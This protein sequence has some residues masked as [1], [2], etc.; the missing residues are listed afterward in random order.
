MHFGAFTLFVFYEATYNCFF[1]AINASSR[2]AWQSSLK[3]NRRYRPCRGRQ[4]NTRARY[5]APWRRCYFLFLFR[6]LPRSPAPLGFPRR[7]FIGRRAYRGGGRCRRYLRYAAPAKAWPAACRGGAGGGVY[8]PSAEVFPL[9]ACELSDF[10][11]FGVFPCR[12][13]NCV[14]DKRR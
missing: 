14:Y 8:I 11:G 6:L 9:W 13:Q 7:S 10:G 5:A 2:A 1:V 3:G 12:F 4:E